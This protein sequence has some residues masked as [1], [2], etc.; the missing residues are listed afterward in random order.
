MGALWRLPEALRLIRV[1][2][3][4]APQRQ[5]RTEA[6]VSEAVTILAIVT[7]AAVTVAGLGYAASREDRR[8]R[9]QRRSDT[10]REIR[11]VLD[12]G[13]QALTE[14]L[15]AFERRVAR[16]ADP[17]E[18]GRALAERHKQVRLL[19]QRIAI[20]LGP[21]DAVVEA[22]KRAARVAQ[23]MADFAYK[24]HGE[25]YDKDEAKLLVERLD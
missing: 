19:Q 5:A 6:L 13:A 23:Q 9:E 2:D 25:P 4:E 17:E 11:D 3:P 14:A 15:V 10:E 18:T 22:Y 20:R 12:T 8:I 16:I 7:P 21:R 1:I 24:A